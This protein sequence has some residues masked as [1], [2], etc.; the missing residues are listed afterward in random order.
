MGNRLV[1]TFGAIL[2]AS[3]AA[4][5]C[6]TSS[7]DT[8][9]AAGEVV[10]R[11]RNDARN[12]SSDARPAVRWLTDANLL[13]LFSMMNARQIAAADV[14]LEAWHVDSVR[15]FAASVAREH[16]ELQHSVDSLSERLHL[17]P[18]A[19]ALGQTISATLQSQLDTLRRT[20]GRALDRAF[21][22]QQVATHQLMTDYVTKFAAVAERPEIQSLFAAAKDSMSAQLSRARTLQ[23]ALAIADSVASAD[24]A[25][26]VAKRAGRTT[27]RP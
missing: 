17:M 21:I 16:A 13:S 26:K 23:M 19:P 18:I 10:M 12:D 20:Y 22:R 27:A 7:R 2:L 6:S 5:A 3:A 14:E 1:T 4:A 15:A 8:N 24:S 25:A 11:A 9:E